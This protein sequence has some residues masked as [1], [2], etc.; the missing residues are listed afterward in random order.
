MKFFTFCVVGIGFLQFSFGSFHRIQTDELK[1]KWK[2]QNLLE[3]A[4]DNQ[5]NENQVFLQLVLNDL[6]KEEQE[7]EKIEGK[8][9]IFLVQTSSQSRKFSG[10]KKI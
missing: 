5:K 8:P 10:W 2:N 7:N 1:K 6:L 9:L 3:A 4:E